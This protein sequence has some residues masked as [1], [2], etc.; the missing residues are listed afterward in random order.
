MECPD[1][2]YLMTALEKECSRCKNAR[3]RSRQ[4]PY[5]AHQEQ[6]AQVRHPARRDPP[7]SPLP[8]GA[9][10]PAPSPPVSQPD[11]E[12]L[13]CAKC[14][15]LLPIG[16]RFCPGCGLAFSQPVP[17]TLAAVRQTV[18]GTRVFGGLMLVLG[19]LILGYFLMF[20]DTTVAVGSF[21]G[22]GSDGARVNNLGLMADRQNGIIVGMGLAIAATLMM[23]FG[24]RRS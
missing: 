16:S 18:S 4:N 8:L 14:S 9:A 17:A 12:R 7:V 5:V 20:F 10:A 3:G 1:C 22:E 13:T 24:G 6:L 19:L 11:P 23:L 2:G 21:M 15:T